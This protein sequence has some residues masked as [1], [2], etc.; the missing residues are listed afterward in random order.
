[1]PV[2]STIKWSAML[3]EII[4]WITRKVSVTSGTKW[5]LPVSHSRVPPHIRRKSRRWAVSMPARTSMVTHKLWWWWWWWSAHW[6]TGWATR[7]V[8]IRR[9]VTTLKFIHSWRNGA[10]GKVRRWTGRMRKLLLSTKWF[11][12]FFTLTFS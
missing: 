7:I 1:M 10:I 5:W 8:F 3:L 6:W 9:I 2:E 11:D 4:R 12:W